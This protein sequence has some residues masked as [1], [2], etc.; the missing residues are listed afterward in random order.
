M[1]QPGQFLVRRSHMRERVMTLLSG[2]FLEGPARRAY[3]AGYAHLPAALL[4]TTAVKARDYDRMTLEIARLALADGGSALDIGAHEGDIL[5]GLVGLSSEQHWAFEPIPAF[6]ARLKRRFPN[7]R[8][9]QIALSDTNGHSEFRFL[10]G[11]AACSSILRR[12]EIEE[13]HVVHQLSILVRTLDDCI[14]EDL[15]IVFVKIDVEG[16]EAAVLRG[17]RRLLRRWQPVTVFECASARLP[18]CITALEGTGLHVSFLAD[19]LAGKRR[20]VDEVTRLG[21]ERGE[22]YYVAHPSQ[23]S[24]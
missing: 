23:I 15:R 17:G 2:S 19:F 14:P 20:A 9:E 18:E 6:A 13:G 11:A 1:C 22:Y 3:S 7:V 21:R 10:P 12:P 16:M 8:V 24:N 5:R 4:P